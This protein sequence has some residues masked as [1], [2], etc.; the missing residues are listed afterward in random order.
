MASS[1]RVAST[2]KITG[3]AL[4][5]ALTSSAC[6][7]DPV[8]VEPDTSRPL[9][10]ALSLDVRIASH[11]APQDLAPISGGTLLVTR[12]DVAVV[13]DPD[14][15]RIVLVDLATRRI[16]GS[17][18]VPGGQPGRATEDADGRV[19]VVLRGSGEIVSF[20]PLHLDGAERHAVCQSPRG[21]AFDAELG[22]LQVACRDG[23]LVTLDTSGNV[24]QRVTLDADDLRDVAAT[25]SGLVVSRFRAA[26]LVG[27][28]RSGARNNTARPISQVEGTD[29]DGNPIEFQPNVA[30]RMALRG[31]V[32]AVAHQRATDREIELSQPDAYGGGGGGGGGF[33]GEGDFVGTPRFAGSSCGGIV[34]SSVSFFD[35][36]TL[37]PLATQPVGATLPV[38]VALAPDG[39]RFA[40]IAAGEQGLQQSVF[41]GWRSS[42][43]DPCFGGLTGSSIP[44]PIAVAYSSR[45]QLVVQQRDPAILY[46]DGQAVALGGEERF[47][48]GH[49]IFHGNAGL[50]LACASCHPEGGDDGHVWSFAGFGSLRTPALHGGIIET[51]PFHWNGDLPSVGALMNEVFE[52]RMG[53]PSMDARQEASLSRWVD[54]LPSSHGREGV[55]TASADRGARLFWGEAQCGNCHVG[56]QY[57]NNETMDVGTGAAFQV[58]SLIGVSFR[59]PVMH[60]GCADTLRAR[61]EPGCGGGDEHGQT[62]QLT[63]SQIDDLVAY[64]E[65]M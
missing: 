63:G 52:R 56:S 18:E 21:I 16:Q 33:V 28:D 51:A 24:T 3:G 12:G 58:P 45:S 31:N 50:G 10:S 30:W 14:R 23:I 53:G 41:E 54:E 39:E 4:L 20:D 60:D 27:L 59:L 62:S 26:E 9:S 19:H 55:D 6:V 46:V 35:A 40:V 13:S 1:K 37:A 17:M 25:P 15:D 38:D 48:A 44:G 49:A 65:T 61:F 43:T 34:R 42:P 11:R 29:V 57:T 8:T 64:L 47:D 36:E 22:A 2:V 5:A 32:L 7:P